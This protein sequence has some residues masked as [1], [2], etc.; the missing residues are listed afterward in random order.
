MKAL[1]PLSIKL[2]CITLL[3]GGL[4]GVT[5]LVAL[6]VFGRVET[7]TAT[8]TEDRLPDLDAGF[9]S[10][11][12]ANAVRGGLLEMLLAQDQTQLSKATSDALGQLE[13]LRR[14]PNLPVSPD[15]L[16]RLENLLRDL[17]ARRSAEFAAS[18]HFILL[19]HELIEAVHQLV[20]EITTLG[21][22]TVGNIRSISTGLA[23]TLS[24][25]I[26]TLVGTDSAA[27]RLVLQTKAEFNR[28]AGFALA[29][30]N[31]EDAG[32]ATIFADLAKTSLRRLERLLP[33]LESYGLTADAHI[34]VQSAV[35]E[36]NSVME[37]GGS[38]SI[39]S[40][41]ATDIVLA[42]VIDDAL[43]KVTIFGEELIRDTSD[44]LGSQLPD[45]MTTLQQLSN[46]N[47]AMEDYL[48]AAIDVSAATT[49]AMARDGQTAMLNAINSLNAAAAEL[50]DAD[51]SALDTAMAAAQPETGL[52]A[53]QLATFEA[54]AA[55][56]EAARTAF[57]A[58]AEL[59]QETSVS[60]M[61]IL[62]DTS[63]EAGSLKDQIERAGW[64][65]I[66][67]AVICAI[68]F[69]LT[70]FLIS[71]FI[72]RPI[73]TITAETERLAKGDNSEISDLSMHGGEI[74][75]L[76]TA[77]RVFRDGQIERIRMEKASREQEERQRKSE[78]EA[79]EK[80]L[81]LEKENREQAEQAAQEKQRREA[82][83]AAEREAMKEAM[84]ESA[85]EERRE[86]MN[87]QKRIVDLL[88]GGLRSLAKGDLKVQI[89]ARFAEEH[90][91]LRAD[92]N[93]AVNSLADAM[94]TIM[95]VSHDVEARGKAI[96]GSTDDVAHQTENAAA[97]LEQTAAALEELT[98]SVRQA[99]SN[100]QSADK[101]VS[102]TS[103]RAEQSGDV[104]RQA[105]EAMGQIEQSSEQISKIIHVIDDIAF[106]T[107]LLALNAGVEAAR[108]G[109]A[110]RG[111]AVV[112]SEVRALAQ[113]ASD[114][115]K[116]I[117]NLI[118][119]SGEHVQRGVELVGEAGRSLERIVSDVQEISSNMSQ[120][121]A[122]AVEQSSGL[123]ELNASVASLDQVT[124]RNASKIRD[125][126]EAGRALVQTAGNLNEA[127]SRFHLGSTAAKG[128]VPKPMQR[129][130]GAE[131]K[132]ATP[133]KPTSTP[134][135]PAAVAP[136]K[137]VANAS[138]APAEIDDDDWTEF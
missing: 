78:R 104:V 67:L 132:S 11:E 4:V 7:L 47:G 128:V 122:S 94:S 81:Q 15:R 88:A 1:G 114:A 27:M 56:S 97:T 2:A 110:G 44:L 136:P 116:E 55:A 107:N 26:D 3:L 45:Q 135:R 19:D 98:S 70:Q 120:I 74:A 9:A 76:N 64:T 89:D 87:E 40:F 93:D 113:R 124:Q 83:E 29:Y 10:A 49:E 115:A 52:A 92:F 134:T 59:T 105:V 46:L 65:M 32:Q 82:E 109:D 72:T 61:Q 125:T 138:N 121:A 84:R 99:T 96:S 54:K 53:A 35:G 117:N 73:R 95:S 129:S 79:E 31:T 63:A 90:E 91:D 39:S 123:S 30:R 130:V 48:V 80:R 12:G 18:E 8:L 103:K 13:T 75:Q 21:D 17:D 126:T 23:E 38:N 62:Q 51:F 119:G 36:I 101:L 24:E 41:D 131:P 33:R 100:V 127:V 77:L 20:R 102:T 50:P 68:V 85:E 57:A 6:N 34:A 43:Y 106:Q 86:L 71:I 118:A 137:K 69:G 22:T 37:D 14:Q 28:A 108:A 133:S 5:T 25:D 16:N 58:V 66:T 112:A 60:G 111:F 42:N